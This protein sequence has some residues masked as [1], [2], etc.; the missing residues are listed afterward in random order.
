MLM[1]DMGA[2]VIKV[3]PPHGDDTRQWAPP[4]DAS[5]RPTYFAAVNRN[6]RSVALDLRDPGD[7]ARARELALGADVVIENFRPGVMARFGLDHQTLSR[8]NQRLISCSI[9]G[10]GRGQGATMPG[11]DL[12]VQAMGGLMSITGEIDGAATKVGVAVVDIITGLHALNGI[13]AALIERSSSGQGQ[14]VEANL[15]SS[16]LSGLVNQVSATLGTGVSPVRAGNQH[17]SIAPYEPY[18]TAYGDLV[19]AVGNDRQFQRLGEVLGAP[20]LGDD[21]RFRSNRDRVLNRVQLREELERLLGLRSAT[22]WA[23]LL[24]PAGVPAG[25][26]NTIGEALDL[27]ERLGLD[28]VVELRSG[29]RTSRQV[30]NPVTF[31]RTPVS[32][33]SAPPDLDEDAG[34]EWANDSAVAPLLVAP[35]SE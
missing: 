34:A 30:A 35:D 32:Y 1:A 13:Q 12:L 2:D 8:A 17:P 31:S 29:S 33:R 19:I 24:Q 28:P 11:Y 26:V 27:A 15:L 16:L 6:K 3:E 25:A 22:E 10:F 5:G 18:P 14:W 21:E 7:L 20:T 4:V 23:E 9:T